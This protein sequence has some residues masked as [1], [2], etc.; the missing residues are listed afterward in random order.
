MKIAV[1]HNL[2]SGGALR[3]LYDKISLFERRGNAVSVYTPE[4]SERDFLPLPKISGELVIEPLRFKGLGRFGRYLS[5]GRR[6]AEKINASDADWVW[7]DKCRF[8]GSPPVL[9][10][11][12]KPAIFY[13]HEPLGLGEYRLPASDGANAGRALRSRFFQ[14]P[15]GQKFKKIIH[16][17]ERFRIKRE[18][19]KSIRSAGLVMTSSHFAARWLKRVYG[20]DAVVNYQGVDADRFRPDPAAAKQSHVLSVGRIEERKN[21]D[22]LVRAISRIPPAARPPLVIACDDVD[23]D[24]FRRLE[25]ESRA[26]GV[27]TRIRYR[28]SQEE[29][30]KL[31]QSARLVL[32]AA[33]SEPFGLVPLEAM[34]CGTAVVAMRDGGFPE[35]VDDGRTGFLMEPDEAAW[36]AKIQECLAGRERMSRMGEAGRQEILSK[37]MWSAFADRMENFIRE[38]L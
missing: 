15:L 12:T 7:V 10:Y 21:H 26:L 27:E 9:Q 2:P 11:L 38:I 16:G 4:T 8:F 14:M 18:D 6:L 35:V 5:A 1:F 32:C 23:E 25:R 19:Q 24:L 17:Y 20:V 30:V 13:C 33:R 3:T 37:W 22:F 34:A 31:Y 29:L 28:P 36:G